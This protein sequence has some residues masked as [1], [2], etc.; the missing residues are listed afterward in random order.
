MSFK[1][2]YLEFE[3][4]VKNKKKRL[5]LAF[6]PLCLMKDAAVAM[7]ESPKIMRRVGPHKSVEVEVIRKDFP[8]L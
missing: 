8:I 2:A 3:L 1:S 7:L 6:H 4:D 5:S